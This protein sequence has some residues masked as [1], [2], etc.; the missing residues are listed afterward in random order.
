MWASLVPIKVKEHMDNF[1]EEHPEYKL[2]DI[3]DD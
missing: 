3:L 2:G 1:F